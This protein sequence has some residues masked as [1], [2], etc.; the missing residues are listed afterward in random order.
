MPESTD[1]AEKKSCPPSIENPA[2]ASRF[3]NLFTTVFF[4]IRFDEYFD[5]E[6]RKREAPEMVLP[7]KSLNG[8]LM[9][10]RNLT[11]NFWL[12]LAT[13]CGLHAAPVYFQTNLSSDISGL[14]ANTDPNLKNPWGMSFGPTTPFWVSDQGVDKTTLYNGAG[15]AQ[16]LVVSMPA[17][18]G[19]TGQVFNSSSSFLLPTGGKALF[20]FATL[21]GT[22]TGWNAGQGTTAFAAV[23]SNGAVYTGLAIGTNGTADM[24]YAADFA[25]ARID[26]FNG[27]FGLT[28]LAGNFT[29]PNLPAGYSP[30]NVQTIGGKLYVEYDTVNPTTGRPTTTANTGIVDIFNTDGTFFQRLVTNN[31]LNS[32][33]GVT[34]APAGFGG[35]GGDLL[36]GN[37]GDGTISAFNPVSGTF[38]GTVSD[39]NGNPLVNSG[40][41]ALNFRASGSGFD[42]NTLFFTAG[43]NN[44]ADGLFGEIQAVPEPSSV[45]L[46]VLGL[47]GLTLLRRK[48]A[49]PVSLNPRRTL[50]DQLN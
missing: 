39:Q 3:Y 31:H 32:P 47:G 41:W 4:V 16:A 24:L 18:P 5:A 49:L 26:A 9:N 33:W 40:L 37:F 22:I 44:E 6:F 13:L 2:T 17:G 15:V 34:L 29:D 30:Y 38:V 28:S 8:G 35:L 20:L 23:P 19:P 42:P 25:H 36:V 11:T 48:R 7:R 46:I 12:G 10:L 21:D 43:I 50:I 27:T 45:A 14:A 1:V